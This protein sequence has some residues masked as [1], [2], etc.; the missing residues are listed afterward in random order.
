MP[1]Q[2]RIFFS[3]AREDGDFALRLAR[4]LRAAGQD[5]WLDQLDIPAGGR[6]DKS[7][8]QAL[9][10][11]QRL[12]V[13]L[14]PAAVNSTNVMD[15]VSFALEEGKVVIPVLYNTCEIPFRLRRVQYVDF[16][17]DYDSA[18][19]QLIKAFSARRSGPSFEQVTAP[20]S[21]AEAQRVAATESEKATASLGAAPAGD[22][23]AAASPQTPQAKRSSG[24]WILAGGVVVVIAGVVVISSINEGG[25]AQPATPPADFAATPVDGAAPLTVTFT[26]QSSGD[27]SERHWNFGDG[28]TS[29]DRNPTY[30]YAQAGTYTVLLE[31]RRPNGVD[32]I[33]KH[34]LIKVGA[35]EVS[36]GTPPVAQFTANPTTGPAP[37]TVTFTSQPT[38]AVTGY[39]WD[40]GDGN[41]SRRPNPRH[42][43]AAAGAYTVRLTVMG[44]GGSNTETKNR[45]VNVAALSAE[46]VC[47]GLV[48]DKIAFD[49]EDNRRWAGADVQRLCRGTTDGAQPATCFNRVMHGGVSW[50]GG[51]RWVPGNAIDLCEGT[52][53]AARTIDCF[54]RSIR[55][56]QTWQTAI[57]GCE[58]R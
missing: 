17:Q 39:H 16:T 30:T 6:W 31:V 15:E 41:E 37:L 54:Q 40:F 36:M 19:P 35:T 51:T 44:P 32:S 8:E 53:S 1:A 14:S 3:Y 48:Q 38:G 42:N 45:F 9:K 25:P 10:S 23:K 29:H 34:D 58:M 56:E 47:F 52:N 57:R 43:Y 2:D 33:V 11:C 50:G 5:L 21:P 22:R 55:G 20:G 4:D 49:Y 27:V 24:K 12:L 26:D 18:L 7:V 13:I 46:A 28:N